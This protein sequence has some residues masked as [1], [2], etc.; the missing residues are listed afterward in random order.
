MKKD[1]RRGKRVQPAFRVRTEVL[2][3]SGDIHMAVFADIINLSE[4]GICLRSP[5]KLTV[6]DKI[7][8]YLPTLEEKKPLEIH[9]IVRWIRAA[10]PLMYEYGM[11]F[12]GVDKVMQTNMHLK[13]KSIMASYYNQ[14]IFRIER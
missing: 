12:S 2:P 10:A 3:E 14:K 1:R 5:L 13:I 6:S 4:E 11:Q 7:I 8:I 9:G